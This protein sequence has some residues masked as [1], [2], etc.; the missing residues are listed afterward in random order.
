MGKTHLYISLCLFENR[1]PVSDKRTSIFEIHSQ[2]K[3]LRDCPL[4]NDNFWRKNLKKS[5]VF[6][7]H[8][9]WLQNI[10][11][12][13]CIITSRDLHLLPRTCNI[14]SGTCIMHR[15]HFHFQDLHWHFRT[16]IIAS[17]PALFY[18]NLSVKRNKRNRRKLTLSVQS[19]RRPFWFGKFS[20]L[21]G[22][23][24]AFSMTGIFIA[25]A[26]CNHHPPT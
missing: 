13:A 1:M 7:Q 24:L 9:F 19:L 14:A 23:S 16:C 2:A 17:T 10:T 6:F 18:R 15:Q 22:P 12:G 26:T 5:V 25:S 11:F 21:S 3:T 4:R 20:F 8:Q